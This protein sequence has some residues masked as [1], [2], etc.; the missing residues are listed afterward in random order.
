MELWIGAINLGMLYAFMTVGVFIT[1]RVHDFPDITVDGSFTCGAA[2]AA[3]LIASGVN[4]FLATAAAFA[5]GLAAGSVTGIIHTR[6]SINGLLAGILVMTGLYSINLHIMGR[7]NIPLLN[8]TTFLSYVRATNPGLHPEIWTAF[9]LL[10]VMAFFWLT[11]SLFFRTDFGLLMRAT[12]NNP[13]MAASV[14]V[15]VNRMKII[16][17]AIANGLTGMSGALVAQYQGFADI[18][19]GIGTVVIGL[20]A[21]IIGESVLKRRSVTITVLSVILGSVIFRLMIAVALYVGMNPV[22]LK[23]LTAA[24]VLATLFV[25][26]VVDRRKLTVSTAL[27]FLRDAAPRHRLRYVLAGTLAALLLIVIGYRQSVA[28]PK[29]STSLKR[30]GLVQFVDNELLNTTRDSFVRELE[31]IG[32]RNGV[33]IDIVLANANGDLPT[34][35]TILDKFLQEGIDV[36]VPVSSACAQAAINKIKDRPVVFATVASPFII[37]AGQ[38]DTEH[39]ANVTGV[40]GWVPME[41]MMAVVRGILPGPI[42]IGTI[43]DPAQANSEFNVN[44]LR[45][46]IAQDPD[47]TFAGATITGSSE[48]QQ[49]AVA[50]VQ[51]GINAFVL[52]PDHHTYAAFESVLKA[53]ATR[54]VPICIADVERLKDGAFC[55]LGYDYT[56]SG[57][58]A[59]HLVDRILKGEKPAK[60]PFERYRKLTFG[61]NLQAARELGITIPPDILAQ[62]N[63]LY[64]AEEQA[65]PSENAPPAEQTIHPTGASG[66]TRRIALFLF[67]ETAVMQDGVKGLTDE[68]ESGDFMKQQDLSME[69]Q[70]AQNEFSMAQS[71]AQDI[72]RQQVDF[73]LTLSTPALQ[74]S[75]QFN[76]KIPH[77][78]GLVTDPYS[79]GI[80]RDASHH[81]PWITGVATLQPVEKTFEVMRQILPGAR[82]VGIVWNPGE[83]CSEA[84]TLKARQASAQYGFELLE[85]TVTSTGEV[86][87][88]LKSLLN[89]GIDAFLTSGDNTVNLAVESIG[90]ILKRSRIPYFTNVPSDVDRGALLA[91]G[92]DYYEVGRETG[93]IAR[94]VIAGEAPEAIPI[95]NYTPDKMHIN[96]ALAS[97]YGL[98]IPETILK[99]A[100]EIR[101]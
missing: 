40:Y 30:V 32:Y 95:E 87:D 41:K 12:G 99:K 22:D 14:G 65:Q 69:T 39:L 57:I 33:T 3:I 62:A 35:N 8:Q 89:R 54:K 80:G 66:R 37:G 11:L 94:R 68:L 77:V 84:C 7:S 43:W 24:F 46:V 45:Q 52:S 92:A 34:V 44:N 73:L 72:V 51:K 93:K 63:L 29:F 21:V 6:L 67:S 17:I 91:I 98:S 88:A 19:M 15:D 56:S 42:T 79:M 97:E 100:A 49:A 61:F 81:L 101:R 38:S 58:Q 36:V 25:S 23:L 90:Q 10:L 48:V 85:A 76:K 86:L 13:T 50:L 55:A 2:V 75:A 64:G 16:G 27:R 70:C 18:G 1:F 78:F 26:R 60:I 96:T 31:H 20:A 9:V 5:A 83:A 82:K 28:P 74:V 59:A 53:A 4:P 47:V 71:I